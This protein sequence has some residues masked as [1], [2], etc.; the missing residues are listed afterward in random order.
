MD[1]G[2]M[3]IYFIRHN[4]K[5]YENIVDNLSKTNRIAIHVASNEEKKDWSN[6]LN[7]KK[8]NMQLIQRWDGLCKCIEKSDV[9]VISQYNSLG[10]KIGI[11]KKNTEWTELNKD[12]DFKVFEMKETK[13]I[14]YSDFILLPVII[15]I[16]VTLSPIKSLR[17]YI[18]Y[19]YGKEKL[20]YCLENLHYKMQEQMCVEWLRSE[21]CPSNLRIKYQLLQTGH[22]MRDIDIY[23]VNYAGNKIYGQVTFYN[24]NNG[25]INKKI[26][27]LKPYLK[28]NNIVIMFSNDD[29]N[30][31]GSILYISLKKVWED[32]WNS[33]YQD[34]IKEMVGGC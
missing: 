28:G 31:K 1:Y 13:S 21:L 19:A 20:K 18:L 23:G 27:K 29:E 7:R 3:P 26:D 24:T 8:L 17:N 9:I 10:C 15:P 4:I 30:L 16:S 12:K 5:K 11:I 2:K 33:E 6:F 32:L 25:K 14:N 22:N 34:M